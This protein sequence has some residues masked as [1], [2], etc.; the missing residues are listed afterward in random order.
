VLINSI[1]AAQTGH[2]FSYNGWQVETS[3]N[4]FAHAVLRG[5]FDQHGNHIPNYH[6]ENLTD[7]ARRYEQSK[8]QNP[9]VIIDTNHSNSAKKY[10]EQPRIAMEVMLHRKQSAAVNALVKGFMIESF[11]EQ[12]AQGPNDTVYG[13]SIT[14]PCLGW[15]ETTKVLHRIADA[16]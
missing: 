6:F 7:L 13:K 1:R 10:E 5:G 15:A 11:I 4:L 2:V 12:G 8:L 14:D 16:M 3:G 9:A